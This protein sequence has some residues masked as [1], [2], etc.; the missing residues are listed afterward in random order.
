MKIKKTF[1]RRN[2]PHIQP[3]GGTFFVTFLLHGAMPKE[4]VNRLLQEYQ[5]LNASSA[6]KNL[7]RE[8]SF[9][10]DDF[11]K[12]LNS[13]NNG[14]HWL[15]KEEIAQTVTECLHFWDNKR[16]ELICYCIMSNHVHVVFTTFDK[17]E[18]NN[19]LYLCDIMESIKKYSARIC[20]KLLNRTGKPFWQHE[21][22][23]RLVRDRDEL[24]RIISY[25]L[26][27]PIKA[28]LCQHRKDWKWSYIKPEYNEFM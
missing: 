6:D 19:P 15:K 21:S 1:Y 24:Y 25:V 16:I 22:Y 26:D 12:K 13:L 9:N 3:V 14:S 11:D 10:L 5:I 18:H 2:L 23:D 27:N 17:D 20:N 7:S 8:Y 4:R 28:G